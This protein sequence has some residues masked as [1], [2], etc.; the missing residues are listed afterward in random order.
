MRCIFVV[1]CIFIENVVKFQFVFV[2]YFLNKGL[3]YKLDKVVKWLMQLLVVV[4]FVK[5]YQRVVFYVIELEGLQC[6][7]MEIL[8]QN[9]LEMQERKVSEFSKVILFVICDLVSLE[10][11]KKLIKYIVLLSLG[12]FLV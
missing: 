7:K 8:I 11:D 4:F 10:V 6:L 2:D 12:V 5:Q 1:K 3:R 9:L